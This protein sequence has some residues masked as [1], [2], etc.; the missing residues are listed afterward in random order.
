MHLHA[1]DDGWSCLGNSSNSAAAVDSAKDVK[2]KGGIGKGSIASHGRCCGGGRGSRGGEQYTV[3]V[4]S[5]TPRTVVCVLGQD[6]MAN[7]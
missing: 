3:P 7:P 6:G 2:N 1:L 4:C 5:D